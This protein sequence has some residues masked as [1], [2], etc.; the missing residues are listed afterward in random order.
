M[1]KESGGSRLLYAC[2]I[3]K[4]Q[5]GN[6]MAEKKVAVADTSIQNLQRATNPI[7]RRK[8]NRDAQ[9]QHIRNETKQKKKSFLKITEAIYRQLRKHHER[10][11]EQ[12]T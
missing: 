6:L 9:I 1:K 3:N 2:K 8:Q 7:N 5:R 10:T 11:K 4:P 12:I